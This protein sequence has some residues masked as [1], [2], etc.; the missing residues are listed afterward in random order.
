MK[1]VNVKSLLYKPRIVFNT[2]EIFGR[3]F[4][5]KESSP[6]VYVLETSDI[7]EEG[8]D[9]EFICEGIKYELCDI[10]IHDVVEG[11]YVMIECS[12]YIESYVD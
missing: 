11:Y 2:V 9:I 8:A 1:K 6:N 10:I 5:K 12:K 4:L 3:T 7:L